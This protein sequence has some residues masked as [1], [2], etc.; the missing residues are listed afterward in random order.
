MPEAITSFTQLTAWQE[1]HQLVVAVYRATDQ[2]PRTEQF[3]LSSQMQRAAVSITSNIAEGFSRA[4]RKE[5]QQ[6]YT[7]ALASLTELQN[8]LLIARDVGRLPR[9]QFDSLAAQSLTVRRLLWGL[10]K[11]AQS[12]SDRKP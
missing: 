1:G 8:Q 11:S 3:G 9:P 6:F 12:R 5:K 2:F 7:T 4:G 10:V